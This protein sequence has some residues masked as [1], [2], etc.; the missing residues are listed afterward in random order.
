MCFTM[1]HK[2]Q[3]IPRVRTWSDKPWE[4]ARELALSAWTGLRVIPVHL[5]LNFLAR[6][7][8]LPPIPHPTST[9]LFGLLFFDGSSSSSSVRS[10]NKWWRQ[11]SQSNKWETRIIFCHCHPMNNLAVIIRTRW[12]DS[13]VCWVWYVEYSLGCDMTPTWY[14]S[15]VKERAWPEGTEANR[16]ASSII[17]ICAR[18]WSDKDAGESPS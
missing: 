7:L 13:L 6:Y 1:N 14:A 12:L 18:R 4:M 5:A 16:R 10:N 8:E 2:R 3:K 9:I 15:Y 11:I 17:R